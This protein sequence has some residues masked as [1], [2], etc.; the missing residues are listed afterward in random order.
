MEDIFE[1]VEVVAEEEQEKVS[2]QER[3]E[4]LEEKGQE[5]PRSGDVSERPT[6]EELQTLVALQVK[7]R[8]A[9]EKDHRA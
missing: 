4:T 5:H 8:S 9:N 3:E 1:E 2:L 7:L 6:L